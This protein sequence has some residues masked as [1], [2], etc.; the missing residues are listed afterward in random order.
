MLDFED[1][2]FEGV[3]ASGRVRASGKVTA[4]AKK[5]PAAKASGSASATGRIGGVFG[6]NLPAKKPAPSATG[7]VG[8]TFVKKPLEIAKKAIAT[9]QQATA[10]GASPSTVARA[11]AIAKKAV[12]AAKAAVPHVSL[13]GKAPHIQTPRA[14]VP[15]AKLAA[16]VSGAGKLSPVVGKLGV[17]GAA[18]AAVNKP[19]VP[20]GVKEAVA[21]KIALKAISAMR[22]KHPKAHHPVASAEKAEKVL[23]PI[24]HACGCGGGTKNIRIIIHREMAK[25]GMPPHSADGMLSMLHDM[26]TM[27]ETAATQRLAT[28]EHNA[29]VSKRDFEHEV[30][31]KLSALSKRLPKCHPVRTRA[32]LAVYRKAK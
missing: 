27:L 15:P 16:A 10:Q 5:K 14:I 26:N 25:S 13:T 30:L 9:A 7:S 18:I 23:E 17:A 12:S 19:E 31:E 11:T 3:S 21:G 22:K 8:G 20:M 32:Q 29:I 24:A 1:I 6:I 2:F 4:K 28:F